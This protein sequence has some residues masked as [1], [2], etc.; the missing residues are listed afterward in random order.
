MKTWEA[1]RE[2][3][4]LEDINRGTK[5]I[6]G[7]LYRGKFAKYRAGDRISLRSDV[8]DHT[9][10]LVKEIPDQALVEIVKLEKFN[11]FKEML[12]AVGYLNVIPRAASLEA[13]LDEY[14]KFYTPQDERKYGVVAVHIKVIK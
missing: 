14:K 8:Y 7:R 9:G 4:L 6:E 11:T 1:G 5:T 3:S 12:T 2:S 10:K 13:A